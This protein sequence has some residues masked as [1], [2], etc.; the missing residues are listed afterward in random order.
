MLSQLAVQVFNN[1]VLCNSMLTTDL[2]PNWAV[3]HMVRLSSAKALL[4][5]VRWF[6]A[7]VSRTHW[8]LVLSASSSSW[9]KTLATA[10]ATR[11]GSSDGTCSGGGDLAALMGKSFVNA[12]RRA[13]SSS[14]TWAIWASY[15]FFLNL[16]SLAQWLDLPHL[17]HLS[18]GSGFHEPEVKPSLESLFLGLC[19]RPFVRC[20]SRP[21][22]P[23]PEPPSS[24]PSHALQCTS[25]S[26]SQSIS[27]LS[28]TMTSMTSDFVH[29]SNTRR[30]PPTYSTWVSLRSRSISIA[31]SRLFQLR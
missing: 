13:G 4:D 24:Y 21:L 22:E 14:S 11:Y 6:V 8:L 19:P 30:P 12:R 20:L 26:S 17:W 1:M 29:C 3:L 10:K 9:T 7:L 28:K 2:S 18:S 27:L 5:P 25:Q 31:N 15:S 16:Q 23:E